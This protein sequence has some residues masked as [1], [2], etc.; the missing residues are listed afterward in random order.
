MLEEKEVWLPV[1]K[2]YSFDSYWNIDKLYV[3]DNDRYMVSDKGRFMRDGKIQETKPDAVGTITFSLDRHRFKLHQIVLQTFKPDGIKDGFSPDH[4][5]NKRRWDNSLSNLRWADKRTQIKN[6]EN[7]EYKYK[8]V[9]CK[10]TNAFYRSCQK[11][12]KVLS[13]PKNTVSRVARGERKTI[14]N[15]HFYFLKDKAMKTIFFD[16]GWMK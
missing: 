12:E 5:D 3:F 7:K 6:R 4:I 14:H 1:K 11:A 9:F 10:E 8:A 2:L 13:L 15:Y 16:M